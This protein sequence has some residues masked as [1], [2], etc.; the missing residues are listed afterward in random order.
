[1]C[2]SNHYL[3][4]G[5]PWT[6]SITFKKG[7][8]RTSQHYIQR[9]GTW[10]I[11]A[12]FKQGVQWTVS[13]VLKQLGHGKSTQ[14]SNMVCSGQSALH[15]NSSAVDS[16]RYLQTRCAVDS[17]HYIETGGSWAVNTTIKQK[18]HGQSTPP[19]NKV[20]G[21]QSALH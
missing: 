8:R 15:S 3:Q 17:H 11:S 4:T 14:P 16:Q 5:G 9:V 13:T 19:A 10:T 20:C 2:E 18:G 1:M 12:T 21:G 6:V 7:V